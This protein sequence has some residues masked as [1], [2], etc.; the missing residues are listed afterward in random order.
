MAALK[1]LGDWLQG[2]GW[3]QALVQ[4]EITN[5]RTADSFLRVSHVGRTRRAYQLTT[6]A[7]FTLQQYAYNHC[8]EL[9]DDAHNEQLES[10]IGV[11]KKRRPVFSLTNGQ[12]SCNWW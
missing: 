7:L 2:S 6:V 1:N 5:T 4:S 3:V 10:A 11:R 9:L 8:I 12:L